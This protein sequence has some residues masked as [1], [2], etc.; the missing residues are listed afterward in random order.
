[1]PG[2][3]ALGLYVILDTVVYVAYGIALVEKS[4]EVSFE[5]QDITIAIHFADEQFGAA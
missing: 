4:V 5:V 2:I 3:P 1:M